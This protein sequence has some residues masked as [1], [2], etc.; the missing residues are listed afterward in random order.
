MI[1]VFRAYLWINTRWIAKTEAGQIGVAGA[2]GCVLLFMA[3][4]AQPEVFYRFF[5]FVLHQFQDGF[6]NNKRPA[7]RV[8]IHHEKVHGGS[9]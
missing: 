4:M 1:E 8:K 3:Y 7:H 9:K 5:R 2:I 6:S